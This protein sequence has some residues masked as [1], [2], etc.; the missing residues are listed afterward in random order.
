VFEL[1]R[2]QLADRREQA[3]V[4]REE[5]EAR[6]HAEAMEDQ[7]TQLAEELAGVSF[8][9]LEQER[10]A[11]VMTW[12]APTMGDELERGEKGLKRL[13]EVMDADDIKRVCVHHRAMMSNLTYVKGIIKAAA[14]RENWTEE[15][16]SELFERVQAKVAGSLEQAENMLDAA[17]VRAKEQWAERFFVTARRVQSLA[18]NAHQ[19]LT[20]E[21]WTRE[22]AEEFLEDLRGLKSNAKKLMMTV[23]LEAC[24]PSIQ[25]GTSRRETDGRGLCH[26]QECSSE[27][28]DEAQSCKER[29]ESKPCRKL[30][31]L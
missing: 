24:Q 31:L 11:G 5:N 14:E 12:S 18:A 17:D 13:K 10:Q 3:C 20:P 9:S 6:L 15:Q 4:R 23:P 27:F 21:D 1:T 16:V 29:K 25:S 2:N 19:Y 28:A 7:D 26:G 30:R 8:L 22:N